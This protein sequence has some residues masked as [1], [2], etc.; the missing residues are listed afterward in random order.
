M[1]SSPIQAARK[2][3]KALTPPEARLWVQL[4]A[5]RKHGYAFRRQEPFRGYFLDFACLSRRLAV[6][7][8]GQHHDFPD[9][10]RRDQRR[11]AVLASEGFATLRIRAVDV[12]DNIEGVMARI[13]HELSRR[14]LLWADNPGP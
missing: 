11:D 10:M 14:P 13:R 3:R 4:K 9:P 1:A 7:V 12:R 8:D 2:M 6:E 5:L